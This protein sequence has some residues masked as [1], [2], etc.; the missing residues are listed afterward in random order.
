MESK[1]IGAI[2]II[3]IIVAGVGAYWFLTMPPPVTPYGEVVVGQLVTPGAPAGTPSDN[4]IIVGIIGSITEIQGEGEWKGAY[5]ACDELNAA[6]G[7]TVGGTTYY[8]GIVAEDT[9]E[10]DPSLDISKGTAAATKL[11]TEDN[12]RYAIGGFRTESV[13]AYQ[14]IFMDEEMLF[15]G[16]GASTDIFCQNVLDDYATYKYFFRTMPINSTSLAS[17]LL[18]YLLYLDGY[19]TAATSLNIT[20]VAIIREDLSWTE[21][22]S[23]FL[24]G[25]L[26]LYN[27]TIV[28]EVA[29]PITAE[30]ADF[31]TYWTQIDAAGAQITVPIISAQGGILMMTQYAQAQPKCVVAGIDVMSQLDTY[32]NETGGAAEY[33][34]V[35]QST[36]RTA[37]TTKTI[38]FWDSFL[39][40]YGGEPLYTAIGAYDAMHVLAAAIDDA[41]SLVSADIIPHL[42]AF[43]VD[44]P[45]E[46]AAGNIAFTPSHDV[47][48]GYIGDTIYSVTLFTQWQAGGVKE[49]VSSGG[50]IY[51]ETVV[52]AP[53]SLPPWGINP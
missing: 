34:V 25:Y 21:G 16:T 10:S 45:F 17:S 12:A 19:L 11:V 14:E 38:P 22:M 48:E 26:P 6:G 8:F 3:V 46:A 29:Y 52:T 1:Q 44:N 2:A 49:A 18:R 39:D 42:E 37:K 33:E 43:D 13:L 20:K 40:K 50:L 35:L 5:L 4:I 31:A 53:L 41:Q 32:W 15:F 51:P 47:F 28:E 7:V 27:L 30:A 24:N 36:L 23:A 9:F